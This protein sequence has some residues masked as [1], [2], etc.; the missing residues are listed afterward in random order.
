MFEAHITINKE[1]HDRAA[2]LAAMRSWKM[3]QIDGDPVMGAKPFA[4]MTKWSKNFNELMLDMN[5]T[6]EI[7]LKLEIPIPVL[8]CKIEA[9]LHDVRYTNDR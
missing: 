3:S 4:Y 6:R 8:R 5:T 7:L 9:V 1:H 2:V